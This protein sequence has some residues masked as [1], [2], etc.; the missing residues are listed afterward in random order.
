MD[1]S[2]YRTTFLSPLSLV[3]AYVHVVAVALNLLL[4]SRVS[5]PAAPRKEWVLWGDIERRATQ[6]DGAALG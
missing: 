1:T 5:M 4:P 6:P 3:G 2:P